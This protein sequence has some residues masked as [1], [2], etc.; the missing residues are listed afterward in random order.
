MISFWCERL[1]VGDELRS[2]V[3]VRAD[4]RGMITAHEVGVPAHASDVRVSTA[5]PGFA[6]AHS[7]LFHRVLRGRTHGDGGDFWAWRERMYDAAGALT[8]DRY[9]RL[10]VA[11]FR[12]MVASGFTAVGEFTYVHH[13]PDGSPYPDHDM[14]LALVS[15]AEEVGI[16]LTLLDTC[17]LDGGIGTP[18][19]AAQRRFGDGSAAAWLDRWHALRDRV[20]AA[21]PSGL[22]TLGAAIHSLRAVHPDAIAAV[23]AGLPAEVPLHMHLSEQ[24]RENDDVRAAYGITPTAVLD[25]LGAL[26]PRLSVVHATHLTADDIAALGRAGVTVVMCPTTE[27]D[28]GDG[29]GPAVDLAAA[30]CTIAIGSDQNAVIDPLLELRGLEAGER[31]GSGRRGRFSPADLLVAGTG[32]GYRSLGLGRGTLGVGEPLDLVELDAA[33]VRTVGSAPE[34]LVLSA[35]AADILAVYVGGRRVDA[36]AR[37][38]LSAAYAAVLAEFDAMNGIE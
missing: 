26:G 15:A 35:T 27:A 7:H 8:P 5:V 33:S 20:R 29:I 6:N 2:G 31:L 18:L 10:A 36:R 22:A 12:E 23:L 4:E 34:Q 3:R 28:L 19:S 21:S 30:G 25:A 1:L 38:D 14:E 37:D 32:A 11:V 17:Y 24:P 9:R 13:R 16:R